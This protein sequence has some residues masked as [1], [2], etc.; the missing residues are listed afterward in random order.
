MEA[1]MSG[2]SDKASGLANVAIGKIKQGI[3][4]AIGS[5]ELK[6]KG[7]AQE[8]RGHAQQFVG[9][10]KATTDESFHT[11]GADR[12]DRIRRRAY[13]IWQEEGSPDGREYDHW[14]R[15]E[16]EEDAGPID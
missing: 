12:A 10:A 2:P 15:A 14:H 5:D 1:W 9:D 11:A 4:S 16:R 7:V 8:L 6:E 13:A 3:G